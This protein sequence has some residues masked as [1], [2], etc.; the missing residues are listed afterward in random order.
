MSDSEDSSDID[1]LIK[2]LKYSSIPLQRE[3]AAY[4]LS[5]YRHSRVLEA[6][7]N[8]QLNDLNP[9]VR[10]S[11]SRA[12]ATLIT[13]EETEG[14]GGE[15][16]D[17]VTKIDNQLFNLTKEFEIIRK[18]MRKIKF[19]WKDSV[20][21][22]Q[23]FK[24]VDRDRFLP[25]QPNVKGL[26]NSILLLPIED[27]DMGR[28]VAIAIVEILRMSS[29]ETERLNAIGCLNNII[30]NIDKYTPYFGIAEAYIMIF[31]ASEDFEMRIVAFRSLEEIIVRKRTLAKLNQFTNDIV[32]LLKF[33]YDQKIRETA[34]K[35]YPDLVLTREEKIP[36]LID[37]MIGI[38]RATY[39]DRL[40]E[41][42]LKALTSIIEKNYLSEENVQRII[43]I[44]KSHHNKNVRIRAIELFTQIILQSSPD[45]FSSAISVIM[46]IVLN[47]KEENICY[48]ALQNVENYSFMNL[49][50]DLTNIILQTIEDITL[51]SYHP[52]VAF[53]AYSIIESIILNNPE[54]FST[55]FANIFVE[56]LKLHK[57]IGVT[58]Q[59]LLTYSD[60]IVSRKLIP[61]DV[62]QF[63]KTLLY[64]SADPE[65]LEG[66]ISLFKELMI[67]DEKVLP[68]KV[69]NKLMEI[70]SK[71]LVK[72]DIFLLLTEL[73]VQD[74][75]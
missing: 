57:D 10:D 47:T 60:M 59:V 53:R 23:L 4:I 29:E 69:I 74:F 51:K 7:L 42:G 14:V 13:S 54:S 75:I 34:I 8:S 28:D 18:G 19:N 63:I 40:R 2:Q 52:F 55:E 24:A 27:P 11:A 68:E 62:K 70:V 44:L 15:T 9:K 73:D 66:V 12:L 6:L 58:E 17:Y 21:L 5:N 36:Y 37:L 30:T 43:K 22:K 72:E 46:S 64:L 32:K 67:A 48:T 49:D 3:R 65:V 45:I 39:E 41:M 33:S 16:A 50:S 1:A 38:V 71:T 31:K 20:E 61:S 26:V 35:A 56:C 25:K